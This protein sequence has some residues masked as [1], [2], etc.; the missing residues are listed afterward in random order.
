[1][2]VVYV[3]QVLFTVYVLRVHGGD[4]AFVARYLPAGWFDL[5]DDNRAVAA[6]AR[7]VPAPSLLAPTVL[8]VQAF[9][10]LPFVVLAYLTA[11]R[12]FDAGLYR[13]LLQPLQLWLA[14]ASYTA[15]F[16]LV[17][18]SLRNPYTG[19]D[20]AL[21]A[22]A[23]LAVPPLLRRFLAAPEPAAG[24]AAPPRSAGEL[25]LFVAAVGALGHLVLVVYDTA[26]LY[27]LGHLRA[28]L[29]G[30]AVAAAV[31]A[32][33]RPLAHRLAGRHPDRAT[34]GPGL[35][36]VGWSL[37]WFLLLFFVPALPVRYGLGFGSAPVAAAA[38]ALVALLAAV[39]GLR[40]AFGDGARP[41]R[42]RLL[43]WAVGMLAS[44][45]AGA[46]AAGLSLS[47]PTGY[48]EAGLLRAAVLFLL[49]AGLTCAA[50]D[51]LL[52]A[53]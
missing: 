20:L 9:C 43:G 10:E 28:R 12:W 40:Q 17:E 23:A 7:H 46:L 37:R 15:T 11:C 27:N 22:A 29:P 34:A 26:L 52:A 36:W 30:A 41:D 16:G 24:T 31:L 45:L 19:Q 35:A 18:W 6:F 8:R 25:G 39:R 51:R 50:V 1:V 5:A 32:A 38:G 13:R 47:R 53:R 3:N 42:R 2:A 48:P 44:A 49:A 14:C 21:R 33:A 4:P